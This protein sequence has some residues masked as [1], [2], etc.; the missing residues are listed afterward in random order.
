MSLKKEML[1]IDIGGGKFDNAVKDLSKSN[2]EVKIYDPF[3]RS[4]EHNKSVVD[5]VK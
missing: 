1:F 4:P 3:N 2:V 5:Q